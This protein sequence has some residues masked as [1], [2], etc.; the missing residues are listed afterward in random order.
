ML[1][2]KPWKLD[3]LVR[4]FGSVLLCV[5]CLSALAIT[6]LRFFLERQSITAG[7]A[8]SLAGAAVLLGA[9]LFLLQKRWAPESILRDV[10]LLLAAAY[11]GFFLL[12]LSARLHGGS[13]DP[14]ALGATARIIVAV[15]CFQT[16]ALFLVQRF[17]REHELNWSEAFGFRNSFAQALMTGITIGCAAVPVL[18]GL[19]YL[20]GF[21]LHAIGIQ[22][23]EQ[24][25]VQLLRSAGG[26]LNRTVLGITAI[27]IAPVSEEVLFRGVLYPA[28][29]QF[30]RPRLA[31]WLSAVL[32]GAMHVNLVSFL[33]LTIFGVVL[34]WL[35]DKTQNLAAPIAAHLVFN[36]TNF[37][38]L[39][40][41]DL[42]RTPMPR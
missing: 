18:L 28:I 38:M 4:L 21:L 39:F 13:A 41:L 34:A 40:T 30:G 5:I 12:W 27:V 6:A 9:A 31:L 23:Q 42:S 24:E 33:P 1:S 32:F 16:A 35:Y 2:A 22:P 26:W 7:A 8:A 3:A 10:A 15:L 20:S 17:L 36:T 25:A 37:V 29:R 11:A 19:Q 14:K